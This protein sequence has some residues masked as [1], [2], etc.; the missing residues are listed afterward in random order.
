MD[1]S[2]RKID[3][4][5]QKSGIAGLI[6]KTT[7][8]TTILGFILIPSAILSYIFIFIMVVCSGVIGISLMSLFSAIGE[9]LKSINGSEIH[10]MKSDIYETSLILNSKGK[11]KDRKI[12]TR[13]ITCIE[14]IRSSDNTNFEIDVWIDQI[15]YKIVN[16]EDID[17]MRLR[18]RQW[19]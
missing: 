6:I 7:I 13:D 19:F 18:Q 17:A 5:I 8:F 12:L 14:V 11:K 1:K 10:L 2:I 4:S 16:L 9:S 3:R 15:Y